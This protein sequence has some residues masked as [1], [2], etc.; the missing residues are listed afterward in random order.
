MAATRKPRKWL[1]AKHL[2]HGFLG[3]WAHG[4]FRGAGNQVSF[5]FRADLRSHQPSPRQ[6]RAKPAP[7]MRLA[8]T[9]RTSILRSHQP[10]PPKP[11][12]SPRQTCAWPTRNAL[13][14]FA[15]TNRTRPN[16]HSN[17]LVFE[18]ASS[19]MLTFMLIQAIWYKISKS[20]RRSKMSPLPSGI[21]TFAPRSKIPRSQCTAEGALGFIY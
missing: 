19:E 6:T 5:C 21:L 13:Q 20:P 17:P 2:T 16:P 3:A 7:N 8:H 12:P 10:N 9:K 11:A 14:S 1:E 15:H 18:E 4:P